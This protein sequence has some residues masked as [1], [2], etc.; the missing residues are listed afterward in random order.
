MRRTLWV[1]NEDMKRNWELLRMSRRL[2][3]VAV[4][5][6]S[7]SALAG[8]GLDTALVTAE[9]EKHYAALVARADR[10]ASA[11]KPIPYAFVDGAI[12]YV[13]PEDW[14]SGFFAGTLWHLYEATGKEEWKTAATRYT[15]KLERI[16]HFNGK[17]KIES[18]PGGGTR[19]AVSLDLPE[20]KQGTDNG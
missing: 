18:S 16:R 17:M 7:L 11:D 9:L 4:A 10:E 5:G 15:E 13:A 6:L 14:C 12:R 20:G 2:M 8:Y 19:I 3:F 1:Y